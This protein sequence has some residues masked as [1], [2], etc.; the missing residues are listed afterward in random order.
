MQAVKSN[1][2]TPNLAL[3]DLKALRADGDST[4]TPRFR[5]MQP[6]TPGL[7]WD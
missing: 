6:P 4:T 2:M 5:V 1:A 7:W 3:Q